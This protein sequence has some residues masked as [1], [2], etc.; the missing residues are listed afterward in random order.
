MFG[1]AA[2][3]SVYKHRKYLP[4]IF[5]I[6]FLCAAAGVYLNKALKTFP[7][8]GEE[9][10]T[11]FGVVKTTTVWWSEGERRLSGFA[12]ASFSAASIIGLS[13]AFI[14]L[15]AKSLSVRLLTLAFGAPAIYLT[16]SK[17]MALSYLVVGLLALTT[18]ESG[19]ARIPLSKGLIIT[20]SILAVAAPVL[21]ALIEPNPLLI[22]TVPS[23]LSSFM[24]R[25]STTW[26]TAIQYMNSWYNLLIGMGLGGAGG[27]LRYGSE[28]LKYNPLDNIF[29]YLFVNFG[30]AGLAYYT[31]LTS[32][33]LNAA[34]STLNQSAGFAGIV[35][36]IYCYGIT[37][38][39]FEDAF[40]SIII[41][42]LIGWPTDSNTKKV[43]E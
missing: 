33:L 23:Q 25:A 37:A 9:F 17:G 32:R 19:R 43:A 7:W 12:R 14:M 3:A 29:L 31:I 38:H 4:T 16:T 1:T 15:H 34:T 20:F 40:V 30:L 39:L 24:D 2:A 36:A 26:P 42:I 22:R 6:L 41:G 21:S 10:E 27:P 18:K 11:A 28:Y 5:T 13:G 35:I 8:E